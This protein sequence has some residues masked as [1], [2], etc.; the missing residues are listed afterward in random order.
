MLA[1]LAMHRYALRV[2]LA[3][4][5]LALLAY[6][7]LAHASNRRQLA[8]ALP[9]HTLSGQPTTLSEL[10]GHAAV[11]VFWASWCPG[12]KAEASAVE[13][14]ARSPAGR[15]RVVAIDYSDGGN[16]WRGFLR[17]YAWTFPVLA[18]PDGVTGDAFRIHFL[19][20]TVFLDPEGRIA[21][22][23]AGAQSV[24]SLTRGLAAAA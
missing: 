22:T 20:T 7:L 12:C 13:R 9:T 3:A 11:V 18:D 2:A 16:G 10:R 1:R 21:A 6:G 14:F 5:I 17:Q 19:P 8:P 4:L 23:A 15:G 24:A